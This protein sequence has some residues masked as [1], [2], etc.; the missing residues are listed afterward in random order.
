MTN[1]TGTSGNDTF[2][3]S[4][5]GDTFDLSQGGNDTATGQGGDDVF[6]MGGAFTALDQLDGGSGTD[7]VVLDGNY[8]TQVV[9]T[10]TTMVGV[11]QLKL[12]ST[13]DY[14]LKT[15]DAT[16][17]AGGNLIVDGSTL[18]VSDRLIFDGT[19]ETNGS[20]AINGGAGNDTL[21][22]GAGNDVVA[23]GAGDDLIN[24]ASGGNDTV[25]GGDGTD[26]IRL[27]AALNAAD[28]IDGGA[29]SDS[30]TLY[31]DYSA[32]LTLGAATLVNV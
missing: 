28:H 11:E 20:F 7:A 17:A 23:G 22:S 5:N 21:A 9:F 14:N 15:A 29:G 26:T 3:G 19:S 1:F 2:T 31:G 8:L 24:V 10:A 25:F 16:V 13:F 4:A 30:V 18:G 12:T 6:V 32:G 27:G